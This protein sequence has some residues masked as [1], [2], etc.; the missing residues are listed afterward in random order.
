M[1]MPE[2]LQPVFRRLRRATWPEERRKALLRVVYEIY[3]SDG[4]MSRSEEAA[5]HELA[6]SLGLEGHDP[7]ELE[8]SSAMGVLKTDERTMDVVYRVMADAL[9]EDGDYDEAEQALVARLVARFGL[10]EDEL[11]ARIRTVRDRLLE[12]ALE[13]WADGIAAGSDS[14]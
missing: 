8:L 4:E 12:D 6:G 3:R 7:R 13:E 5:F 9:F 11:E 2:F 14:A 10:A 1:K